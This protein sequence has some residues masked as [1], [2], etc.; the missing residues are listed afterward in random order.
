MESCTVNSN[1]YS[2]CVPSRQSGWLSTHTGTSWDAKGCVL[3]TGVQVKTRSH[4]S[5]ESRR[6]RLHKKV[7]VL[8]AG[9]IP[10]IIGEGVFRECRPG[11]KRREC[12][13]LQ[14]EGCLST[15]ERQ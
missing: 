5:H 6:A 4:S 3:N 8:T 10:G 11:C 12:H 14:A 9:S 1:I 2:D 15:G 7:P 13:R